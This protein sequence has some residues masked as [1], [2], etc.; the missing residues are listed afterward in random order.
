MK[1]LDFLAGIALLSTPAVA[2]Q[3]DGTPATLVVRV[4]AG[5]P[6]GQALRDIALQARLNLVAP[7]DLLRGRGA[8]EVN[9]EMSAQAAIDAKAP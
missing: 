6:L 3:Q 7:A 4:K 9:G 8:P 2:A 5:T 1:A